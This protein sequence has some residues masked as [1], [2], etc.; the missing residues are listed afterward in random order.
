MGHEKNQETEEEGRKSHERE[1]VRLDK[2]T[3]V[4]SNGERNYSLKD[5]NTLDVL[6][7]SL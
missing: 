3:P 7:A 6:R 4:H 5:A 2:E 1:H